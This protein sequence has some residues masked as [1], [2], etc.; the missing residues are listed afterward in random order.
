MALNS[1]LVL[2]CR[3]ETTHSLTHSLLKISY[4]SRRTPNIYVHIERP[5]VPLFAPPLA[6]FRK[7][8]DTLHINH[9]LLYHTALVISSNTDIIKLSADIMSACYKVI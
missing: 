4:T 5:Y 6:A 9:S 2:M 7:P 8:S 3:K 1:L